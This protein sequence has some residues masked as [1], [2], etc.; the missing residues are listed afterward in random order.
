[1]RE[2]WLDER[3]F[4]M[5]NLFNETGH[6][7]IDDRNTEAIRYIEELST[8]TESMAPHERQFIL[9]MADRHS[10]NE[11]RCSGKQLYWLRDLYMKFCC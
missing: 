5:T 4:I 2:L 1:M 6:N 8:Q 11:L 10:R 7:S 9:D 3:V